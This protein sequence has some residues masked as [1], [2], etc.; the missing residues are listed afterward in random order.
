M[1]YFNIIYSFLLLISFSAQAQWTKRYPKVDGYD[2]HVYLEAH[3]LPVLN[4]GPI[5]PAPS[6]SNDQVV[7][8]AKGWLWTMN[9]KTLDVSEKR[10]KQG[11]GE[12]QIPILENHFSKAREKLV[13]IIGEGKQ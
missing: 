5:N 8:A 13:G 4:S 2:H 9:L 3:E 6:P 1:R 12:N 7:F 10:L 11:Y